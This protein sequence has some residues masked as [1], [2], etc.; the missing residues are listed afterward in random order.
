[1]PT[2]RHRLVFYCT[3]EIA[4]EVR[5]LA[6]LDGRTVS[7]WLSRLVSDAVAVDAAGGV[8]PFSPVV[9]TATASDTR[10]RLPRPPM[11]VEKGRLMSRP[12]LL[13][14]R[15]TIQSARHGCGPGERCLHDLLAVMYAPCWYCG[16]WGS[17]RR[18]QGGDCWCVVCGRPTWACEGCGLILLRQWKPGGQGASRW[19]DFKCL[20][21]SLRRQAAIRE[22]EDV[23][24]LVGVSWR[25]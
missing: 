5:R 25:P 8:A 16:C 23:F 21:A 15:E 9:S 14:E 17:L 7:N 12:F 22:A 19:C 24:S 4:D 13:G 11:L 20:V 3:D 6:A 10:R 18:D 2:S 1:M